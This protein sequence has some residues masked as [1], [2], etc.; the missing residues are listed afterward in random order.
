MSE[1][2]SLITGRYVAGDDL[3]HKM[4]NGK[5]IPTSCQTHF[6]LKTLLVPM[7]QSK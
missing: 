3:A 2:R 4:T 7:E 1:L 6:Q 5:S